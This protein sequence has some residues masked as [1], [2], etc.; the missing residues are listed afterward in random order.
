[1]VYFCHEDSC[2]KYHGAYSSAGKSAG[3]MMDKE[4]FMY[5]DGDIVGMA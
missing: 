2:N 1:V 5:N 4:N 3:D